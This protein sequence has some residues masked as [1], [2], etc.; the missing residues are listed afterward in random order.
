MYVLCPTGSQGYLV[1]SWY[2]KTWEPFSVF[3]WKLNTPLVI[4]DYSSGVRQVATQLTLTSYCSYCSVNL[5][6]LSYNCVNICF[7]YSCTF[8][9]FK[10]WT[11]FCLLCSVLSKAINFKHLF[12]HLLQN[13]IISFSHQTICII[14]VLYSYLYQTISV[15]I[16]EGWT[17][18][19]S[20]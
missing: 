2:K 6:A 18:L 11:V 8:Q 16:A 19:V 7:Y 14:R 13:E 1:S 5:V 9:L 3:L 4:I 12:S 15:L 17:I 10:M 20:M